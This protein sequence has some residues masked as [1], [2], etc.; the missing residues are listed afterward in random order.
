M[1]PTLYEDRERTL[2]RQCIWRRER[3]HCSLV[4]SVGERCMSPYC[5]RT[6]REYCSHSA[7]TNDGDC[8]AV[9]LHWYGRDT[10]SP[11]CM[12][13]ERELHPHSICT[14]K[15]ECAAIRLQG[16]ERDAC[17][18]TVWGQRERTLSPQCMWKWERLHSSLVTAVGEREMHVPTLYGE[19]R[20]RKLSP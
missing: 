10:L 11:H 15:R 19:R 4:T 7:R 1:F 5:M 9:K 17:P 3:L 14:Q 6:K 12:E 2:I 20:E 13:T 16:Y 8:I 18:H